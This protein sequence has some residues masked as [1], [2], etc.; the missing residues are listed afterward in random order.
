MKWEYKNNIL[1][2]YLFVTV[3]TRTKKKMNVSS[4]LFLAHHQRVKIGD[5]SPP[6]KRE[7]KN[8][9]EKHFRFQ[10]FLFFILI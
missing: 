2:F 8:V 5:H 3:W 6:S 7:K 1:L 4:F 9:L 10:F